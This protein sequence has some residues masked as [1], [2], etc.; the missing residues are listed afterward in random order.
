MLWIILGVIVGVVIAIIIQYKDKCLLSDLGFT[1]V[2]SIISA[3]V[4]FFVGV[5][6]LI[7]S[8][9]IMTVSNIPITNISTVTEITALE[10]NSAVS[11]HFFLGS[12]NIDETQ[13]YYYLTKT[14]KGIRQEKVPTEK[15]YI[16]Y[17]NDNP[18][19]VENTYVWKD[20]EWNLLG[21]CLKSDTCTIYVP[22]GSITTKFNIDL[23]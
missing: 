9:A 22:E 10:D 15:T 23:E 19:I 5:L 20:A 1:I 3:C 14:D 6:L 2:F 11:G 7:L 4:G 13:Y 17:D 12:G 21:F 18:K 8:S 16:E